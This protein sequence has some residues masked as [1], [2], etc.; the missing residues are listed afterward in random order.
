MSDPL[1][2]FNDDFDFSEVTLRNSAD[3]LSRFEWQI[4]S[5]SKQL[6]NLSFEF[7]KDFSSELEWFYISQRD[8]LSEEFIKE[9]NE[10][11]NWNILC[12]KQKD[13]FYL[14]ELNERGTRQVFFSIEDLLL[15]MIENKYRQSLCK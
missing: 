6:K 10:N 13:Q 2:I 7:I 4:L 8:D 12:R 11:L 9:F 15:H 14:F 3:T 5:L 1:R